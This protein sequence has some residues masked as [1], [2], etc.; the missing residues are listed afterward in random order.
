MNH[1][2]LISNDDAGFVIKEG[3]NTEKML[4]ISQDKLS[5]KGS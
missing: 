2:I 4:T 3:I 1:R 5:S